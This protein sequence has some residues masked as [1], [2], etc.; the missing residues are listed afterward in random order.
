[1]IQ[2]KADIVNDGDNHKIRLM[3]EFVSKFTSFKVNSVGDFYSQIYNEGRLEDIFVLSEHKSKFEN[4]AQEFVLYSIIQRKSKP[5]RESLSE[6]CIEH[7][8]VDDII[9]VK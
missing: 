3:K 7:P 1:M 5:S 2:E 4:L 6:Y 8:L 9:E